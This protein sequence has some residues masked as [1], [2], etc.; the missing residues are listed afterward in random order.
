M[1]VIGVGHLGKE[2]A[3]ILAGMPDVELV[4]VADV[5]ADQA[6][7]VARRL[8][9]K[10]YA[11]YWPLLNLVDATCVVVPT[12]H[13]FAVASEFLRRGI[14][15]LVEKPLALNLGQADALADLSRRHGATL[16]VGHIERFNPA[17]E[18]LVSRTLQPKFVTCE[19]VGPFSGRSTDIGVVLDLMIHDLDLLL[20]LVRAPVRTVEAVGVSLFGGHEDVANARL[21]FANGCV[22]NV[23]ASRAS[24]VPQRRMHVWAP[25]GYARVDFSKRHLTLMQPSARMRAFGLDA[26]SL[27]RLKDELFSRHVEVLELE[28]NAE[29]DQLTRELHDFVTCLRTGAAPRVGAAEGRNAIELAMRV[30]ASMERHAW[31]GDAAGPTGPLHLPLPRGQLFP[32]GRGEAAA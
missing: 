11:D 29:G 23:T 27:T 1:A 22:A 10:A 5:N 26:T 8:G 17:F 19:R 18:D 15:V 3:R 6:H 32:P 21:H 12:T 28:R 30:L 24:P 4:G 2:H 20:A 31:D 13:H 14:P 16:Q 7:A 25:E 9:T